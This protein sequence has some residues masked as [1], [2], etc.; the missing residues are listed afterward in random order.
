MHDLVTFDIQEVDIFVEIN[1]KILRNSNI[2]S[3]KE[4][5]FG[6]MKLGPELSGFRHSAGCR[7]SN[8]PLLSLSG[9]V[10]QSLLSL[11]ARFR[12]HVA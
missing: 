10:C 8:A 1:N 7:T 12:F 11:Q 2:I 5:L 4:V 3:M 6:L 9:E